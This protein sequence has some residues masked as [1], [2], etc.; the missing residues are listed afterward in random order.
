MLATSRDNSV[1]RQRRHQ[2]LSSTSSLPSPSHL[3]ANR[4]FFSKF[5]HS[6]SSPSPSEANG[7]LQQNYFDATTP[8]HSS[9]VLYNTSDLDINDYSILMPNSYDFH[10]PQ[11][12]NYGFAVSDAPDKLEMW[13]LGGSDAVANPIG[14]IPRASHNRAPSAS[15]IGSAASVS[16]SPFQGQQSRRRVHEQ[17]AGKRSRYRDQSSRS[18]LPTPTATP[19]RNQF[20]QTSFS[21][22]QDINS[23]VSASMA[24]GQAMQDPS[25]Y[26]EDEPPQMSHSQRPSFSS[27]A[28]D[29]A[30]PMNMNDQH[31]EGQ[32]QH[33]SSDSMHSVLVPKLER[34]ISDAIRDE[35]YFPHDLPM[36]QPQ[37]N[38]SYL[39]PVGN[40]MVNERLLEAQ[41]ARSASSGS[42]QSRALSP[43]RPGYSHMDGSESHDAKFDMSPNTESEPKTISP[44]DALLDYKPTSNDYPLFPQS[45]A[46]LTESYPAVAPSSG[47]QNLYPQSNMGYS[48]LSSASSGWTTG[49]SHATMTSA[50]LQSYNSFATPS[51]PS[52]MS[53]SGM[54]SLPATF[55]GTP[56][57]QT[58][59]ISRQTD[60]TPEFPA[61][62]TS[63]ESSASEAAPPSSAASSSLMINSPKPDSS[64][65]T[66]T[67]SCTY[68][69]CLQ[70]FST[71]QK[72]Q[73]HKRD[74]HRNN[75]N[76]TPGV[77]S[78]MSTAQL[79]E[80]NSQTGPHKC[81]RINPTTGKSCNAIFSRPYDL[82]RHEDTIHNVRKQKVRCA[83]CTEEKSFSRA[84]ALTRHMRVVH[85][86]IDFPGKHTTR[87]K[88]SR[89]E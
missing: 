29:P 28:P 10:S 77:G 15:S 88:G 63:M 46:N 54:S 45:S 51:L 80:R 59:S 82:T 20:L 6:T 2:N 27:L 7:K 36:S 75:P 62:L 16:A 87:R 43:F 34:T 65:D 52:H 24:M 56:L 70:R 72:L 74:A 12:N 89:G 47:G 68:H 19:T 79:M 44:K 30:T 60:R 18:H 66:G 81:E 4:N 21:Q 25:H 64:A 37:S 84:D 78:G 61:Q 13:H 55:L 73:K 31:D 8:P 83:I 22:G 1:P 48:S 32:Q 33:M 85:P 53:M 76:V 50:P 86:E 3:S 11:S 9:N 57:S 58:R 23:T 5:P 41:M 17:P 39:M 38:P 35:L 26:S 14:I 69:G 71:P 67:Y 40:R 49:L 42:N